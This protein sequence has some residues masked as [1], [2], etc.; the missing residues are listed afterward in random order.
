MW[1]INGAGR[2]DWAL[3]MDFSLKG[4]CVG[5]GGRGRNPLRP[6]TPIPWQSGSNRLVLTGKTGFFLPGRESPSLA[7]KLLFFPPCAHLGFLAALGRLEACLNA[8]LLGERTTPAALPLVPSTQRTLQSLLSRVGAEGL[9][10]RGCPFAG[11][12]GAGRSPG[13]PLGACRL[14]G[15]PR[16]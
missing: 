6:P 2:R 1:A 8:Q 10:S 13:K 4:Q 15:C 3:K 14:D 5:G 7:A 11:S 16:L 9:F 12:E